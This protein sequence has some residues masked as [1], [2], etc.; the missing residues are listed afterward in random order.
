MDAATRS[1]QADYALPR[2]DSLH[3]AYGY[4][5][6]DIAKLPRELTE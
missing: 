2:M 1:P 6:A 5:W 3:I 4:M